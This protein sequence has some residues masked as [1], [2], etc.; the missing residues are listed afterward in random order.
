MLLFRGDRSRTPT[1]DLEEVQRL[2]GQ[3]PIS[4]RVTKTAQRGAAALDLHGAQIVEAVLSL[5]PEH[6]YKSMEADLIPGLWQDVYHC[7]YEGKDLYIKL[8]I[9]ATG[10]A[11]VIQFKER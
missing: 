2:V 11:V 8:Q 4:S 3:G 6:F 10:A 7:R 1:Y 9:D 5:H